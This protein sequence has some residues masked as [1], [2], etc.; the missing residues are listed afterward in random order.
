M[1]FKFQRVIAAK[2]KDRYAR[3]EIVGKHR[4]LSIYR[5]NFEIY[6]F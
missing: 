4:L 2:L 6:I 3:T 5:Q 1:N